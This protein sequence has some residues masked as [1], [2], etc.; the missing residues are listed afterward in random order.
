MEEKIHVHDLAQQV[1][2][3]RE[4]FS[5]SR[6]GS[7]LLGAPVATGIVE[8]SCMIAREPTPIEA[9]CYD[10]LVCLV[11]QGA[12]E[13][14]MGDEAALLSEG[15]TAIISLDMPALNRIVR[16]SPLRPYVALALQLDRALLQEIAM[17]LPHPSDEAPDTEGRE[18]GW[19]VSVDEADEA[20]VEA[21]G[22]LFGLMEQSASTQ[23]VLAPLIIKE[24]HYWL[25][26]GRQGHLLRE[27]A[28]EGSHFERIARAVTMIRKNFR[29]PLRVDVL[30]DLCG[31]SASS[32]HAHFKQVTATTP[33]QF[34]KL[35]R[36]IEARR[37][38]QQRGLSVA[39]SAF[40]VGYE[41]PT[42][43]SREYSRQFGVAPKTDIGRK[44]PEGPNGSEQAAEFLSAT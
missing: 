38:L 34:Q 21:L 9:V 16:A 31:M 36:L 42:Q 43:F 22:R 23:A 39:Q 17:S 33:L 2:A 11:L 1:L 12:K 27:L 4:R 6:T 24:I 5:G 14:R 40:E 37:L 8:L 20:I 18:G 32:F 10:A 29:S 44:Q 26:V 7:N 19:A 30:A 13:I 25:V 28:F 35:L 15:E 41:S 3:W